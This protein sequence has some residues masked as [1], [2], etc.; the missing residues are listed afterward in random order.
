MHWPVRKLVCKQ[1]VFWSKLD[2]INHN[3][4]QT[5]FPYNSVYRYCVLF[6]CS[7]CWSPSFGLGSLYTRCLEKKKKKEPKD[8]ICLV[9]LTVLHIYQ[10]A[11]LTEADYG[12]CKEMTRQFDLKQ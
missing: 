5:D 11:M 4:Q 1:D 3:I 8:S 12:D 7:L 6:V 2:N 10:E 9:M